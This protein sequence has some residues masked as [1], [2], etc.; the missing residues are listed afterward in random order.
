MSTENNR[1][2]G[3]SD[4]ADGIDEYD[5]PLP[6]W[7]VGLFWFT[8]VWAIGYGLW[9]HALADRSQVK[10]LAEEMAA[11][12]AMYPE[13]AV[14]AAANIADFTITPE[15]V[16]AGQTVF[17]QNCVACHG[18]DLQGIIGPSFVDDEWIHGGQASQIIHIITVG[19]PDKGMVPWGG[20]LSPEQINQVAAFVITRNSEATGRPIE[21]ILEPPAE[22]G[23]ADSVETGEAP[24][25]PIG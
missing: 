1:L 20:I 11:A 14:A 10:N 24:A 12:E 2:L 9:Y 17:T 3:H 25:E 6:D 8:I 4:E 5:N 23:A 13:Q 15:A 21:Q 18:A 22:E 7:W 19:V 16:T